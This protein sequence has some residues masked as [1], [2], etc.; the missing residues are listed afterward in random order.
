MPAFFR[1]KDETMYT[2]AADEKATTVLIYTENALVRGELVTKQ[3]A[4]VS[5]WL[6]MQVEVNYLHIHRP[7][8][9]AFGGPQ[10]KSMINDEMYCPLS[11]IYGFHLAPPADEPLDYDA[12]EPNRAMKEA[13]LLLGDF[14]VKG[15]LRISTHADFA[16]AIEGVH[17]GWLSVYDAEVSPLFVSSFPVMTAPMMLVNPKVVSFGV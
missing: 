2:L 1:V 4:R 14:T 8:I 9:L 6:R 17:A 16:T 13:N 7:Q 12:S 15:N 10:T 3:S 11:Q 5:I